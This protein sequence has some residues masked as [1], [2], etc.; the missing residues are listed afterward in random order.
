MAVVYA[1]S[2]LSRAAPKCPGRELNP[3]SLWP[4]QRGNASGDFHPAGAVGSPISELSSEAGIHDVTAVG[5]LAWPTIDSRTASVERVIP[6]SVRG[7][8]ELRVSRSAFADFGTAHDGRTANR[9][10]RIPSGRWK[11]DQVID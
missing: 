7:D 9:D 3:V 4:N 1:A 2:A 8:V 5:S 11:C 6:T 10:D